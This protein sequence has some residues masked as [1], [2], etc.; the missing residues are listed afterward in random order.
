MNGQAFD[1][2]DGTSVITTALGRV[3]TA[4]QPIAHNTDTPI[5]FDSI[6][7][8]TSIGQTKIQYIAD[9]VNN[10]YKWTNV[11]GQVAT[12]FVFYSFC[13]EQNNSG[14]RWG[15]IRL[16]GNSIKFGLSKVHPANAEPTGLGGSAI[17]TLLNGE[18]FEIMATQNSNTTLNLTTDQWPTK[19]QVT[20]L[21]Q[22]YF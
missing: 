12:F 15:Y 10:R 16:N 11:S 19:C 22:P 8:S 21:V 14:D 1:G 2:L 5:S 20:Q 7:T 18:Y 13:I 6:D 4:T 3:K 17:I 9:T